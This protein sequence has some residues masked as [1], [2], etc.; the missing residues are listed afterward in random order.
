MSTSAPEDDEELKSAL[1]ALLEGQYGFKTFPIPSTLGR[2]SPDFIAV[3]DS[4]RFVFELKERLDDPDA[5]REERER[6][7]KG[8]VVPSFQ[9]MGSNPRVSEKTR[10]GVKQLQEFPGEDSDFHLLWLHAGGRDPDIQV[11]QF[12]ATLYGT[13]KIIDPDSPKLRHCYYFCESEFFRHRTLLSGAILS[14]TTE[15]QVCI[16]TLSLR[17]EEF[18]GSSLIRTFH[19][20]LLDPEREE[21][22]GEGLV[23]VADCAHDRREKQLI[24]D[25]LQTKYGRPR[26]MDM[27]F[28]HAAARV[29]VPKS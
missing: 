10:D 25:Y 16:N 27:Q 3:K 11:E 20:G 13:T 14:T 19:N 15:L 9:S 29:L 12:R 28:T 21:S 17:V 22:R 24:L 5:L 1:R 23:Y 2:R 4:Q 18:R 7:R 8:E 6:L 26:L